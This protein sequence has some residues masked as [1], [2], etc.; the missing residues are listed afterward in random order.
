MTV[1]VV[2]AAGD[3]TRLGAGMPK[4]L[5]P[6][7]GRTLL[8]WALDGVLAAD[9]DRVVVAAPPGRVDDVERGV[10]GLPAVV[11]AGGA[12]RQA[13]V[14]AALGHV[15]DDEVVLVHDAARPLTPP[16]VFDLVRAEVVRTGDGV[17]PALTPADT[18]KRLAGDAVVE[19]VRRALLA[20]VQTPQGFPAGALRRALE[21]ADARHTDDAAAFAAAGHRV[22]VVEGSPD[23]F[24]ITTRWD[25]RRAEQLLAPPAATRSGLGIDVHA[26]A[27]D[28]PMR[29]GGLQWPGPGLAGHSDADVVCHAIADALLSAGGLGD[30]GSR[31][32]T[33]RAEEAGRAGLDFVTRSVA[34]L[35]EAGFAPVHVA[36]QV[37]G[38]RPRIGARRAEMEALLTAAVGSPVS[39]S[40]TTTDGLGLTG[41]GEGVAAVATALVAPAPVSFRR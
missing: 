33:D 4:A 6:L 2:V 26:F 14:L 41:R 13:S 8:A 21:S 1:A 23:A 7:A 36:V 24:K 10:A 9:V 37:V 27:D 15:A 16:S 17:I 12:D 40:G 32:G 34:L 19:T 39:V 28:R 18:I 5:V 25:L 11:V 22:R 30:L 3:G 20:A 38:N 31:F 35:A 29:L